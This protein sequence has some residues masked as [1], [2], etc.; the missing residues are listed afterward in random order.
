MLKSSCSLVLAGLGAGMVLASG[1]CADPAGGPEEASGPVA[2]ALPESAAAQQI[3]AGVQ[4]RFR[5][6]RY[7]PGGP[8]A[9]R[10][11]LIQKGDAPV[12]A[13]SIVERV[14]RDGEGRLAPRLGG[15]EPEVRVK[16]PERAAG[17]FQ[18]TDLA[19]DTTVAVALEGAGEAPAEAASGLVVYRDA[20]AAG[21]HLI[22]RVTAE[23]TEDYAVLED[24]SVP[25]LA[26]A[27]DL[28]HG[29]AGLRLVA[30]TLE[31][32]DATGNPRL[33]VAPPY[34]V[35]ADG[36]RRSAALAVEGCAVDTDPRAPWDRPVT[37]PGA[38]S[39]RVIVTWDDAGLAYPALVDPSWTFTANMIAPRY[40]HTATVLS[41]GTVLAVGGA[42]LSSGSQSSAERYNPSTNVW[43]PAASMSTARA[44]HTATSLAN[45]DVFVV[46]GSSTSKL[47]ETFRV[48][49]GTWV[50]TATAMSNYREGHTATRLPDGSVLVTGGQNFSGIGTVDLSSADRYTP[51]TDSWS[52]AGSMAITRW[53]H[54]ATLLGTN[55]VLIAGGYTTVGTYSK[56][57]QLYRYTSNAWIATGS[58][59]LQHAQHTATL[60]PNGTVLVAG[61]FWP[62][63]PSPTA[64]AEI[65]NPG[66][67]GTWGTGS[68]MPGATDPG[69][70]EHTATLLDNGT[71]LLT[72]GYNSTNGIVNWTAIYTPSSNT[73]ATGVPMG[74]K[75]GLHAAVKLTA[76]PY[77]G[78]VFITGGG[79]DT[80][81]SLV[82]TE[83]YTP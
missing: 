16:L 62:S 24:R 41:D 61:G 19:S 34:V 71:V 77:A 74:T 72:G 75:R 20:L 13:S 46:G 82:N 12:V 49:T 1:G 39:C 78:N 31:M 63:S 22:H 26:Y 27:L 2:S 7:V 10:Y 47:G 35:G 56:A 33:R 64:R 4:A 37:A 9:G 15:V 59:L 3:V 43:S 23:G 48:S 6:P 83:R 8:Q 65:Y 30:N 29:V 25:R 57:C 50:P 40:A 38:Q 69:R 51:S 60:L 52:S 81:I 5:S 36:E 28:Q 18:I 55:D 68:I 67:A 44:N 11:G 58:M 17:A 70:A 73:W 79:N 32:L 42:D 14:E 21:A 45:G 54:T 76:A 66:G 53:K 80:T